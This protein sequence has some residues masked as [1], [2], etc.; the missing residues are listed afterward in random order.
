MADTESVPLSWIVVFVVLALGIA[1]AAVFF[2]GG[3]LMG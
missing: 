2:M 3:S 1:A